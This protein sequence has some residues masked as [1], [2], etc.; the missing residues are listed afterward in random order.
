MKFSKYLQNKS[1][2]LTIFFISFAALL[3]MLY[4]FKTDKSLIGAFVLIY[5]LSFLTV[6]FCDFFRKKKFYDTLNANLA[7]LDKKYLVSETLEKPDFYEGE[8]LCQCLYE[9]GKSMTEYLNEYRQDLEDFKEYIELWVHEVKIP[10]ASLFL[11]YHNEGDENSKKYTKQ[12]RRLDNYTDQAL[13]YV[14][15]KHA[16]NDYLVKEISLETAIR[17]AA[18]KNKD[19][20]LENGFELSVHDVDFAVMTDGKW[21]EFM[22]NQMIN[23][24]VKYK[25]EGVIPKIEIYAN[26]TE[27]HI[28]LLVKD[29][30]IGIPTGDLPRV[31]QK[32]FTGENGRT[33]GKSTGMGL[34]II[35]KLCG[36]LGCH[37]EIS[38]VPEESTTLCLTFSKNDFY[39]PKN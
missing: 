25:R 23:N 18:I 26:E 17:N 21:L 16:Q 36:Q 14:R 2:E 34:Y 10:I 27:N 11:M 8:L 35:K 39:R 12:L 24:S 38:S 30:G 9:T 33:H 6:I 3:S 32:S 31:F 28:R 19:D 20:L 4:A 7:H 29:N 1:I 13:Y 22:L 37:I 5:A 15:S